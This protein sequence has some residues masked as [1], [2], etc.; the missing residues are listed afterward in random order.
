MI[1][2]AELKDEN[3][4]FWTEMEC[5][6]KRNITKQKLIKRMDKINK[7]HRKMPYGDKWFNDVVKPALF[8]LTVENNKK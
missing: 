3:L 6:K 8:S 5:H 2:D 4:I 7:Q 1:I